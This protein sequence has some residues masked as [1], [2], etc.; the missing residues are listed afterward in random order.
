MR[1]GDI[2]GLPRGLSSLLSIVLAVLAFLVGSP[3]TSAQTNNQTAP[4]PT[5]NQ[6]SFQLKAQSNLVV[7]RVVVRDPQ[8]K[9]V[10]GLRK[11]DFKLFDR[12]KEQSISQF[13]VESAAALPPSTA[14]HAPG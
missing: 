8:G 12:G 4:S 9:P 2:A 1:Q 7:V 13:E 3:S 10:E 6:S 11:E 5:Q 14:V